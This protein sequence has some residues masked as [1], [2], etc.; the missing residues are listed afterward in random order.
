MQ[1][2]TRSVQRITPRYLLG[3]LVSVLFLTPLAVALNTSLKSPAEVLDV[4]SLPAAPFVSNYVEAWDHVGRTFFN[5]IMITGPA[6][7][8]SVF[9][10]ALGAYPC[11]RSRAA[12]ASWST[13]FCLPACSCPTRSC[14][15]RCSR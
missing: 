11:R 5:S 6:V 14:R 13:C 4:L 9:I 1:I 15:F 7:V 2:D 12:P 10:G 3:A 8:F